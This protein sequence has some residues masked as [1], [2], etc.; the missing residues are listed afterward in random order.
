MQK[1]QT[2]YYIPMET[3]TFISDDTEEIKKEQKKQQAIHALLPGFMGSRNDETNYILLNKKGKK[4]EESNKP[5]VTKDE[6]DEYKKFNTAR[7]DGFDPWEHEKKLDRM[8]RQYGMVRLSGKIDTITTPRPQYRSQE[9]IDSIS[10]HKFESVI[11]LSLAH[12]GGYSNHKNDRG[13]ETKWGITKLFLQD[14]AYALPGGKP[15]EIKDLT[16]DDAKAMYKAQWDKYRLGY[17]RDKRLAYVLNDYM[18]NSYAGNVARRLQGILNTRG[19]NLKID[20]DIGEKTLEAIHNADTD[21]LI[22]EVLKDRFW[23]Y[24]LFLEKDK[25]QEDF[26]AGWLKRLNEVANKVGFNI[27][28]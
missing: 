10:R 22:G 8:R 23:N 20:G 5:I 7:T 27:Q 28:Y 1:K 12:E 11:P 9:D 24:I 17:I 3:V 15:K 6:R 21:W 18:I 16:V 4:V 25:S 26:R 14:Y 13:G 19:A 2:F